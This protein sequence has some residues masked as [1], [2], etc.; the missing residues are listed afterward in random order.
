MLESCNGEFF[1]ISFL[2][3]DDACPSLRASD[4]F[5][6]PV[7][8]DEGARGGPSDGMLKPESILQFLAV[9]KQPSTI[10]KSRL[11]MIV[12]QFYASSKDRH[13]RNEFES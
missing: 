5:S 12:C 8:F 10:N 13:A 1:E 3:E 4:T 11:E 2:D 9:S 7:S 6:F